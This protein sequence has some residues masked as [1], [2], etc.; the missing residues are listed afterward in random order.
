MS[1][2]AAHSAGRFS[3]KTVASGNQR[4]LA[5]PA[6][7]E[8]IGLFTGKQSAVV[9]HPAPTGHGIAF[10]RS[11]IAGSPPIQAIAANVIDRPRRTALGMGGATVETVE[12]ILSALAGLGIDNALIHVEGPEIPMGDGSASPFVDAIT[13]AG[14]TEQHAPR[15]F[16]AP[17]APISVH[18][19]PATITYNPAAPLGPRD[20]LELTYVL[21]YAEAAGLPRQ[22]Y[23]CTISPQHYAREVAPARTFSTQA[24]AE[25]ASRA[26][27]FAHVS[28]RDMLVIG[29]SGPIDN[30][31]RFTDEPARH[32]LLDLLGDLMLAGGPVAGRIV[33]VRSGHALNQSMARALAEACACPSN[34]SPCN[35]AMTSSTLTPPSPTASTTPAT[36][37]LDVRQIAGILPHRYPMLMVDRVLT[38]ESGK[39]AVGI[40]NVSINEPFFVG[41]YPQAPIMPGV[42]ICEAMAQLA[43]L[44]LKDVLAHQGKVALLLAMDEVRWRRAVVPGDQLV[45]EATAN[46]AN[47]RMADVSCKASVEGQLAAEARLK[48]MMVDPAQVGPGGTAA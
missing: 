31:Y 1:A 21:D 2:T 37:A 39:H 23:T 36:P 38:M 32:K 48:F 44:M 43:G 18:E 12:H 10:Q 14:I 16:I 33:A 27:M 41:H 3:T 29:P 19:G 20:G 30:T 47:A 42:L 34:P 7:V 13:R 35:A 17:Q 5:S 45:L 11:D 6:R 26:G 4:T 40:K 15:T 28:P 9:L 8:G 46:K 24:E 25:A 22:A